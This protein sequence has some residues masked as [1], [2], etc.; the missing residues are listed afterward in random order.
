MFFIFYR[1]C[2]PPLC[3]QP[4]NN[5]SRSFLISHFLISQQC[6]FFKS[7]YHYHHHQPGA[8]YVV[9]SSFGW[10]QKGDWITIY[11]RDLPG[12]G[13]LERSKITCDFT[14][15]SFDLCI[16]DLDSKNYRVMRNNLDKDIIS[17]ESKIRIKDSKVLIKLKKIPG[18]YGSEHWNEL[19]SKKTKKEKSL[20]SKEKKVQLS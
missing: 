19:T 17:E 2:A 5:L 14:K 20:K 4:Y 8:K 9:P 15:D 10:D 12:V 18:Q 13:A 6:S 16:H 11:I 7:P 3:N 1:P